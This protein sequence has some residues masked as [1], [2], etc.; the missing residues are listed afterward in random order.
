MLMLCLIIGNIFWLWLTSLEKK[1]PV[2]TEKRYDIP[3]IIHQSWKTKKVHPA[4][5]NWPESWKE[6][7]EGWEYKLWTDPENRKMVEEK[8]P[9]F[10]DTYAK[11]PKEIMRADVA[12][13][14]YM[15][16]YGGVYADLDMEC[17]QPMTELSNLFPQGQV[18]VGRMSLDPTFNDNMPNAFMM[19]RAKH[20]VWLWVVRQ[21]EIRFREQDRVEFITGPVALKDGVENYL[22]HGLIGPMREEGIVVL[23][24]EY[25]Y[26]V[27]WSKFKGF[28]FCHAMRADFDAERCKSA[29]NVTTGPGSKSFA[30]TYW[31]HSWG[32]Q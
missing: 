31:M 3:K 11:L 8:F 9:W 27:D 21:V 24:P 18:F 12:R 17:L 4:F 6:K 20:P 30:I 5:R 16:E 32:A 19:S 7:N 28:E 13:Y 10:L 26:P 22:K 23:D 14:L 29:V 15:Y 2:P 25:I 1:R